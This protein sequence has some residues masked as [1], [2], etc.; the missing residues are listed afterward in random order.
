[1]K[2]KEIISFEDLLNLQL[3][4]PEKRRIEIYRERSLA[5]ACFFARQANKAKDISLKNLNRAKKMHLHECVV[6]FCRHLRYYYSVRNPNAS[7]AKFYDVEYKKYLQIKHIEE[8]MESLYCEW[9][10]IFGTKKWDQQRAEF[11]R[12]AWELLTRAQSYQICLRG[13]FLL[14]SCYSGQTEQLLNCSREALAYFE[15]LSFYTKTPKLVFAMLAMPA[16]IEKCRYQECLELVDKYQ[17]KKKNNNHFNFAMF[18]A[19]TL[20]RDQKIPEAYEYLYNY[21][22]HGATDVMKEQWEILK[23]Y[24]HCL[25]DLS[26]IGL[27]EEFGSI[28]KFLN[29]IEIWARDKK[30]HNFNLILLEILL[31]YCRNG[32]LHDRVDAFSR[33]IRR[34]KKQD[35]R[36]E[37]L[38]KGLIHWINNNYRHDFRPELEK[39]SKIK[40][41]E[42]DVEIIPYEVLIQQILHQ[43]A[44]LQMI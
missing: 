2:N 26:G 1:M 32:D 3:I 44:R 39:L 19:I 15:S 43:P 7:K 29:S 42:V 13:Y 11:I 23:A 20:L 24:T 17:P 6:D 5:D 25:A 4:E 35:N 9:A 27:P 33:Y 10:I 18:K 40:P 34:H 37:I 21:S 41:Q 8:E 16:L 22:M 31:R 14:T 36:N 38:L 30:G 12:K 28:G